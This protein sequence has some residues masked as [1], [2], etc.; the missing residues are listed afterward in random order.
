RKLFQEFIRT[1]RKG[2]VVSLDAEGRLVF[3][4]DLV[5][6]EEDA[7]QVLGEQ[8]CHHILSTTVSELPPG[9]SERENA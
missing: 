7:R 6:V 3:G 4:E 8:L 1:L 9:G 2:K 5:R